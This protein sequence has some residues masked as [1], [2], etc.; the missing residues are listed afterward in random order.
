MICQECKGEFSI[1]EQNTH[2]VCPW[3]G[4]LSG[5][6]SSPPIYQ[7][8]DEGLW[9]RN[10]Q[11][12]RE[13]HGVAFPDPDFTDGTHSVRASFATEKEAREFV[14][15]RGGVYVFAREVK[16]TVRTDWEVQP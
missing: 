3:C 8:D 16:D 9:P 12:E 5:R 6:V 1:D 14:A 11:D 13:L 7:D 10:Y 15:T 4:A 2:A